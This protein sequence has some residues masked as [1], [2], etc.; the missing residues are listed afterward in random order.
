M[1]IDPG[2]FKDEVEILQRVSIQEETFGTN[3]TAWPTIATV[4]AEVQDFLPSRSERVAEGIN[5]ARRPARIRMRYGVDLGSEM[6]L[7][8]RGKLMQIVSGPA[9]L[10]DQQYL[11]IIA[12]ESTTLGDAA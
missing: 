12:E 2:K 10:G 3:E 8:V 7:R 4:W 1:I 9:V 11:E 6:R 5:L